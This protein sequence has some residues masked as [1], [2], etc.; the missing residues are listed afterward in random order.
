MTG[1]SG[2]A[3]ARLGKKTISICIPVFNEAENLP[4]AVDAVERL[5]REQLG[6]YALEI[7]VTDNGSTD[8]T[9]AVAQELAASRPHLRACRFSRNFGYQNSVY[10]GLSLA[11]GDAVIELDADLEDPPA[12]IPRFVAD[13]EQGYHVVYGVRTKRHGPLLLRGLFKLY[14]R[15]FNRLASIDIPADAGDFRLLDRKVVEVLKL[16]PERH[17]YLRGL[18]PF[19]GFRQKGILYERQ[20]RISGV[21]K[22]RGFHYVLLALDAM[23]AFSVAPLRWVGVLG[24]LSFLA[25]AGLALYYFAAYLIHGSPVAGF[26]TLVI[27]VLGLQ[28]INFMILSLMGEYIGRVFD[29]VKGRPRVVVDETINLDD[30]PRTL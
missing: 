8:R 24:V 16:L 15:I 29:G 3:E 20:P 19:I 14:Y 5:F 18:V 10:A 12:V 28:S 11:T 6:S 2:T 9:W 27:L 23:T 7:V 25:A 1:R 30:P 22:F 26:A 21:S 13:W 17:L 4:V